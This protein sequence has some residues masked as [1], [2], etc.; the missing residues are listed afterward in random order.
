MATGRWKWWRGVTQHH[1][2]TFVKMQPPSPKLRYRYRPVEYTLAHRPGEFMPVHSIESGPGP[3][4]YSG[5]GLN[6]P[7]L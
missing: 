1:M 2:H 4:H 3:D 5:A 6:S 7:D